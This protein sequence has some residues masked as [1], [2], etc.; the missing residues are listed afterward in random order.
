MTAIAATPAAPAQPG[1]ACAALPP[2]RWL[3]RAA[4]RAFPLAWAR[5]WLPPPDLEEAT[6]TGQAARAAGGDDF[7]GDDFR[8]ALRVLLQALREEAGLTPLGRVIA[9]GS[10]L[11]VLIERAQVAAR[12][13]AEPAIAERPLAP[14]LVIAGPMRS[15]TTRLHR[16]LAQDPR[17]VHLRFFE[18]AFPVPPRPGARDWR[19]RKAAALLAL[20]RR[21]NPA[22]DAIHPTAPHAPDEELPLFEHS[23]WGAQLEAQ[24]PIPSFARWCEAADPAPAYRWLGLL[25]RLI[26]HA[27]GDDPARPWLL[28][29]PQHMAHLGALARAFPGARIIITHRDP[30]TVVA[31]AASLAINQMAIQ[32]RNPDPRWAGREWLHKTASRVEAMMRDRALLPA[33]QVLDI[34]FHA[35]NADWAGELARLYAWAGLDWP[36]AVRAAQARWLAAEAR[37]GRHRAHRYRLADFGLNPADVEGR[38]GAY[39]RAFGIPFERV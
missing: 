27:R 13:A 34:Q 31:S 12:L 32:V 5:G 7:G 8:P 3:A 20:L 37:R 18:A 4:N 11:K 2:Q 33:G 17:F 24:R 15:G 25:L 38:L 22:L 14:P 1:G 10:A 28:K 9:H 26:G 35:M 16:L 36:P 39:R 19:P 29:T 30:Q 21:L 6:L 23:F